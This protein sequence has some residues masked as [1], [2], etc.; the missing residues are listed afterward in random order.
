LFL[1]ATP[2]FLPPSNL[3]T[4][5]LFQ[6][7]MSRKPPAT[8]NPPCSTSL[9]DS[10]TWSWLSLLPQTTTFAN[11][12]HMSGP[13]QLPPLSNTTPWIDTIPIDAVSSSITPNP[14]SSTFFSPGKQTWIYLC[15]PFNSRL[16]NNIPYS[17]NHSSIHPR[18][19]RFPLPFFQQ[20][21]SNCTMAL[22]KKKKR[23][24]RWSSTWIFVTYHSQPR[25]LQ[26]DDKWDFIFSFLGNVRDS[27]FRTW[28]SWGQQSFRRPFWHRPGRIGFQ[29]KLT[30]AISVLTWIPSAARPSSFTNFIVSAFTKLSVTVGSNSCQERRQIFGRV[31]SS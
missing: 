21:I 23:T 9:D 31:T 4:A 15:S 13:I 29:N 22:L 2:D 3:R 27:Q 28:T 5:P 1:T 10:S 25:H 6:I 7:T 17:Q 16:H 30:M 19:S 24:V 20:G 26:F 11:P 8:T 12:V 18:K 14:T